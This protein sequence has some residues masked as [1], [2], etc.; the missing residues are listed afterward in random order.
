[1][2]TKKVAEERSSAV[3]P[4]FT[5]LGSRPTY[6]P[7]PD[8]GDPLTLEEYR[9]QNIKDGPIRG[10]IEAMRADGATTEILDFILGEGT[11]HTS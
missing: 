11:I 3:I 1:M 5:H 8:K 4:L 9:N 6:Y 7:C 10:D 2:L